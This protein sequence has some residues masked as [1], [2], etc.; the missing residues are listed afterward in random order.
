MLNIILF[1]NNNLLKNQIIS[2]EHINLTHIIINDSMNKN[3]L[4]MNT[5]LKYFYMKDIENIN[6]FEEFTTQVAIITKSFDF[7]A[8]NIIKKCLNFNINVFLDFPC[9]QNEE[10]IKECFKIAQEHN[11]KLCFNYPFLY[12]P[13]YATELVTLPK[14]MNVL[15]KCSSKLLLDQNI[16]SQIL[17]YDID[18]LNTLLND[19]PPHVY[20]N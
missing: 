18:Y 14:F 3:E 6:W 16:F 4:N 10:E 5:S 19:K 8:Y 7:K 13:Q 15:H 20:Y 9:F 1:G 11:V 17:I 2:K 12:I